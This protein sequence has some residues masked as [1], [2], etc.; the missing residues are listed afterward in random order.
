V[1]LKQ[2]V[3]SRCVAIAKC[4][5]GFGLSIKHS[6]PGAVFTAA[7][8]WQVQWPVTGATIGVLCSS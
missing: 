3:G 8:G 4:R 7:P 1:L 5:K 2:P 6:Q